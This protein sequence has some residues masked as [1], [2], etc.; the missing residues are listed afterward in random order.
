MR[1]WKTFWN[2]Y[3]EVMITISV[4]GGGVLSIVLA[5]GG[6]VVAL[7]GLIGCLIAGEWVLVLIPLGY[8]LIV[9]PITGTIFVTLVKD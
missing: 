2:T 5:L 8:L 3:K 1:F 6:G 7:A 9:V 4:I